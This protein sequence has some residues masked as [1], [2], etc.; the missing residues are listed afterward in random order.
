MRVRQVGQQPALRASTQLVTQTRPLTVHAA[1]T[2]VDNEQVAS[3]DAQRARPSPAPRVT[4]VVELAGI[5]DILTKARRSTNPVNSVKAAFKGL[6]MLKDV[7]VE[8]AKR[9]ALVDA[10]PKRQARQSSDGR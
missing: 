2:P 8:L 6:S 9:K 4:P 10:A 7:D 1:S 5:T 3:R